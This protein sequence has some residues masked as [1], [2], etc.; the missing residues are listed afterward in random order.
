MAEALGRTLLSLRVLRQRVMVALREKYGDSKSEISID[1]LSG[2]AMGF[3]HDGLA[4][5]VTEYSR[6][7]DKLVYDVITLPETL[8]E[9][10][11]LEAMPGFP[12]K[13]AFTDGPPEGDRFS[14]SHAPAPRTHCLF[15]AEF[16]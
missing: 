13:E 3:L 7:I 4:D 8:E 16:L 1:V 14:S 15:P 2:T 11:R 12:G 6:R 10:E 9:L 5:A